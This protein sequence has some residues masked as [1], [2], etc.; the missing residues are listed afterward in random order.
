[1]LPDEKVE[2][3]VHFAF[4]DS[5]GLGR[6]SSKFHADLLIT[7]LSPSFR[8]FVMEIGRFVLGF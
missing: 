8:E 2:G 4:G 3:T 5:Y 1:M 6:S 7:R